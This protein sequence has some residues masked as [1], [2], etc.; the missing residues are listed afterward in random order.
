MS[1]KVGTGVPQ[2]LKLQAYAILLERILDGRLGPGARL[3]RRGTALEL[4]MS[5]APVHEAMLQLEA[6]GLLEAL[7]RV[8]TRVRTVTHE[9]VRGH[10]ILREAL[11]CQ[12]ARMICGGPVRQALPRLMSLAEA[13]D[14]PDNST[15]ARAR[16]E[17]AF[18]VAL[19]ELAAC[20]VLTREYRR[21]MQIGLFY[22]INH[23][24]ES[25]PRALQ[26]LHSDLLTSLCR[27]TPARAEAA[28][29]SHIWSGKPGLSRTP[30]TKEP[31]T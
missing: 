21:V 1:G 25:A 31:A 18:H 22:R 27:H 19:V 7:P 14:A 24:V 2:P 3:N 16:H 15:H 8:G 20:A 28:V 5:A 29:R 17:V 12:A 30:Q 4:G 9:E 6:D 11:E 10:L 26:I 23:V 13:V